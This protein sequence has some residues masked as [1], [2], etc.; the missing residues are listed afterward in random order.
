MCW[1][2]CPASWPI[3][4]DVVSN[5]SRRKYSLLH[6]WEIIARDKRVGEQSRA[7]GTS[8]AK[9]SCR[10][11]VRRT[12]AHEPP[13]RERTILGRGNIHTLVPRKDFS[14]PPNVDSAV[15]VLAGKKNSPDSA[16]PVLP[17]HYYRAV[18][19]IFAQPRKKLLNNLAEG[20]AEGVRRKTSGRIFKRSASIP[21]HGPK[22]SPSARS[23]PSRALR[24]G[25]NPHSK[26]FPLGL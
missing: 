14:P 13:C 23:S 9:R 22:T 7:N 25:D 5:I 15:I 18:R 17:A 11:H 3:R 1:N 26:Q 19:A 4:L 24:Y 6:Y 16:S 12:A 20:V 21:A 10:A 2:F 8:C